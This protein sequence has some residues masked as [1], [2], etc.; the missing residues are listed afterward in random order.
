[1]KQLALAVAVLFLAACAPREAAAPDETAAP[2]EGAFFPVAAKPAEGKILVTLPAPDDNGVMLR[3]IH[4]AGITAG[5][6]SNPIGFDRGAVE[7]G[8]IIAFR[9]IGAKV[10]I[11]QENW[12]Y[13]ASAENPLEKKSVENSFARSF[14]WATDAIEE[15]PDGSTVFDLSGFLIADTMNLKGRLKRAGQ[16]DYALAAERSFP[17]Y[18]S[19]LVFPYNVELDAY[20]T[21]A[22]GEA[23]DEVAATAADGRAF[24]LVL[25]HSFVR[26]P[27]PGFRPRVFDPRM[28]GI[29]VPFYDFSAP[30]DAPVAQAYARRFRLERIDPNAASGPVKKP[31]V[32]HV[33]PGAPEEVRAALIEGAS[34]WAEAF[35]AAGFE[36]AFRVEVLPEGAHPMDVRYNV[37]QW[38]HRQTRGWSYGG[39]IADPRTGEMIKAAVILGSQRVRQDRMI[40]EGLAGAEK[41]GTGAPDDPVVLAL[42]RI[43][44]LSAHEVG[45]PLGFAHNFA[46]SVNDRASVMD[47][48]APL[49]R[50]RPDGSLDFSEAYAAGVGEWDKAA[51]RWLYA[52]FPDGADEQAE[53]DRIVREAY[54]S[55]LHFMDDPQ[56]RPVAGA[57]PLASVWDNGADPVAMLDETMR[58][59]AIAL[60]NFGARSLKD[61]R[62]MS[63]LRAVIVPVYLYHRYQVA[64]AA[65]LVGGYAFRYALKGEEEG[66]GAPVPAERQR[67]ALAA[68]VRTLDPAALDLPDATL[69]MLTPALASFSGGGGRETFASDTG[70]MFD[71]SRAADAAGAE[72]LNALLNG[73]RL[74]RLVETQRRDP[75]AL[76]PEEVFRAVE[77]RVFAL[78]AAPRQAEIA[79]VLQTRFVSTLINLAE[80]EETPAAVRARIE[81]YLGALRR[82]LEPGVFSRPASSADEGHRA[83]LAARIEAHLDRPAPALAPAAPPARIPPG[84]PIGAGE[85]CWFCDLEQLATPPA[86]SP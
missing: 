47:Y 5:L 7:S 16:G 32:F 1:M 46:A 12:T 65:K 3:A 43:R 51:A 62:P 58:V 4:A 13:R 70:A 22:G 64:A 17:D 83:F 79:R 25:H 53:L 76:S 75:A 52:Q 77:T 72:T 57:H 49:V 9:K 74:A 28:N 86:R 50:P 84:P 30:L 37:I 10:V 73:P 42:A 80:K 2:E 60:E 35:E 81:A 48:P 67:A 66:A 34:W 19:V 18:S 15:K 31:I 82:R 56:G 41:T 36:D 14:L 27:E 78:A 21:F 59:R 39:G 40:F 85:D 44:Q 24:T 55:G 11:E 61:G 71:L 54:G 6:G 26:L 33:D 45:H 38:A 69:D 8:R 20:V 23:G 68:L 63:D 29:D